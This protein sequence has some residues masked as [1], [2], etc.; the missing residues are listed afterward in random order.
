MSNF[1]FLTEANAKHAT[2]ARA[3]FT[4]YIYIQV[5]VKDTAGRT[6]LHMAAAYGATPVAR[7]LLEKG[8]DPDVQVPPPNVSK[9]KCQE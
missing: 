3:I 2:H 1:L 7:L 6:P 5:N 9:K 8:A 4:Y